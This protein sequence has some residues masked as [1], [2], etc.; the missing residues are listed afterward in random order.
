MSHVNVD[1]SYLYVQAGIRP[2]E[3]GHQSLKDE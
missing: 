2:V 1:K 3:S